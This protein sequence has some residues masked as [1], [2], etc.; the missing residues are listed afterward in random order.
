[1]VYFF[2]ERERENVVLNKLCFL[3]FLFFDASKGRSAVA[4]GVISPEQLGKRESVVV[5]YVLFA[6]KLF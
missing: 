3:L 1:M 2:A 6:G 5:V 4:W